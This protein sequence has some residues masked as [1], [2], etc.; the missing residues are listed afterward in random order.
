MEFPWVQRIA[1]PKNNVKDFFEVVFNSDI[2]R[3]GESP[4]RN[5]FQE[6]R[7]GPSLPLGKGTDF[8]FRPNG[9]KKKRI[10]VERL[11]R[12]KTSSGLQTE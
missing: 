8:L 6:A 9:E 3:V 4:F 7:K 11:R 1:R 12:R 5:S 10:F 2:T